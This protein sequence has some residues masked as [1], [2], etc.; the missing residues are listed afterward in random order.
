MTREAIKGFV[1]KISNFLGEIQ[2][3]QMFCNEHTELLHE[4]Q[5]YQKFRRK[6]Q[7]PSIEYETIIT[8]YTVYRTFR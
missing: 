4:L 5:R 7:N 3:Y 6:T 1:K 8:L 2:N